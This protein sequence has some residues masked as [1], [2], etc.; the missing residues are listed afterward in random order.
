MSGS[1]TSLTELSQKVVTKKHE[2]YSNQ[3][4]DLLPWLSQPFQ[5]KNLIWDSFDI[6][7]AINV[8]IFHILSG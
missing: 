5:K 1:E 3:I 2:Y 4:T 6:L 8:P 7:K